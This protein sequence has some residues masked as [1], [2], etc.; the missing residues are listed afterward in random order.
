MEC[1]YDEMRRDPIVLKDVEDS[2]LVEQ[3]WLCAYTGLRIAI[4]GADPLGTNRVMDFHVE[5]IR[6]QSCC[7]YGEDTAYSNLVA[8]WPRPNCGFEPAYG[9][10][11][12][13]HWPQRGQEA[14]F[15]SPL[16]SDCTARFS[17]NHK[18]EITAACASDTSAA[19][20]IKQLG[21]NHKDLV[22]LRKDFIGGVLHPGGHQISLSEAKRLRAA[23]DK[24]TQTL[25]RGESVQ[26]MKFCFAVR[27]VLE[28]EIRK[29]ESIVNPK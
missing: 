23:L 11:K 6:P 9:A 19:E 28:H 4:S 29:L 25:T 24:D 10:R 12:K 26:L 13:D 14:L 27:Q 15:V 21:L 17:F 20:T 22:A 16:R 5:H 2:L 3:G 1:N 8:C 7:D 18:G